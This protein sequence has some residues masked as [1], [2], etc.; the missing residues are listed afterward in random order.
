M[1]EDFLGYGNHVGLYSEEISRAGEGLGNTP[2][3]FSAVTLISTAY[4]L[5]RTLGGR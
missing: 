5:D 1:F 3:G 2:Q 4:N